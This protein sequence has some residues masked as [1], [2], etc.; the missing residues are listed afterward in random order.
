MEPGSA[1]LARMDV[2]AA[3]E[4]AHREEYGKVLASLI[5]SLGGD[6]DLAEEA[7]ADAFARALE[8][9]RDDGV[10]ERPGA[11][12][13]TTARRRALDDLRHRRMRTRRSDAVRDRERRRRDASDAD[14][15]ATAVEREEDVFGDD[16]LRLLYT[17]CHPS[18]SRDASVALTLRTL[19]GLGTR[20]IARAFVVP[21]ATM[22]QRLVRVK[23]KIRDAGIPYRVPRAEDLADRTETVLQVLYLIFNEGW[24]SVSGPEPLRVELSDEALRLVRVLVELRPDEPEARGLLALMLLHDARRAARH[25]AEGRFVALDAQ[26]RSL[27]DAQRIAEGTRHLERALAL[28]R[29]GPYQLQAAISAVHAEAATAD[30]T[31][32][33]RIVRLYDVLLSLRPTPIVGLNRAVAVS[34]AAGA[35]AGL[36]ALTTVDRDRLADYQPFHAARA[37][38]LRR[39]GR[40]AEASAAYRR[41]IELS[42]NAAERT[43][44]QSRLDSLTSD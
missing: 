2:R 23:R 11:W 25:D 43:F 30:A 39:A 12:L 35:E 4:Q 28:R 5:R 10:P 36:R 42:G 17:C 29:P 41:A 6:F 26:D 24:S 37:D 22:A 3:L 1:K 16:R 14:P 20:E 13:L 7:L 33:D 19:G 8:V 34:F 40:S 15:V 44:L 9:W 38:L 32:W 18:L 31:E 27:W 21:E